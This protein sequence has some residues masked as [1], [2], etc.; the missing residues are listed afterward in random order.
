MSTKYCSNILISKEVIA[1]ARVVVIPKTLK[2]VLGEEGARELVDLIEQITVTATS[3]KN[4]DR[5]QY[6]DDIQQIDEKLD[7]LKAEIGAM[8][9]EFRTSI[10]I[11]IVSLTTLITAGWTALIVLLLK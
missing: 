10:I 2:D 3:T 7:V 6:K 4:I 5:T 11:W 9:A 8:I 1:T